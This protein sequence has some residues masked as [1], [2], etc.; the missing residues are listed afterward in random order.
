MF[1]IEDYVYC[2]KRCRE[3]NCT[4]TIRKKQFLRELLFLYPKSWE[5][6]HKTLYLRD[7]SNTSKT[8]IHNGNNYQNQG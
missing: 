7:L 6:V 1:S 5:S 8:D 3:I 2:K 4:P